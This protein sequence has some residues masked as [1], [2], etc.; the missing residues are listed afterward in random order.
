[1]AKEQAQADQNYK[2]SLLGVNMSQ[3]DET[4]AIWADPITKRLLV[5]ATV[6]GTVTTTSNPSYDTKIDDT[7]TSNMIYIGNAQLTGS[8]VPTSSAVWQIKRL[9]TSTLALDK[10]WADGNDSFD[11]VWDNRASLTYN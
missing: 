7:T 9:D 10:K 4:V 6:S 5:N 11:N 1:M 8:A 3:V 2:R